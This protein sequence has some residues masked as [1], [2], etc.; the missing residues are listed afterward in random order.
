MGVPQGHL[1]LSHPFW[2]SRGPSQDSAWS[3]CQTELMHP[4]TKLC[5]APRGCPESFSPA[6][7]PGGLGWAARVRVPMSFDLKF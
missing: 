1:C 5:L 2:K 6:A 7:L 3:P 4:Y